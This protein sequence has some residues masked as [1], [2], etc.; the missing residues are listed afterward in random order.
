MRVIE[1]LGRWL[2]GKDVRVGEEVGAMRRLGAW[3]WGCLARVGE[4]G[5]LGSEE[6]SVLRELGKVAVRVLRGRKSVGGSAG[7][8]GEE[9]DGEEG[10]AEE[11]DVEEGTE[12]GRG[13]GGDGGEDIQAQI[14][15]AKARIL[16]SLGD[17]GSA[18]VAAEASSDEEGEISD[19]EQGDDKGP[20]VSLDEAMS[21]LLDMI[22]TVVGEVYGQRDLLEEREVW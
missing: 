6:V 16:Q 7:V 8:D 14:Q 5:V 9:D 17:E 18:E 10:E 22:I 3:C 20:L 19:D 4:V 2:G 1:V 12:D 21:T 13:G 11:E 15:A